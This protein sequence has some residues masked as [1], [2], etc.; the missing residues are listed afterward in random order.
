MFAGV[1]PQR[2]WDENFH[3]HMVNTQFRD[4]LIS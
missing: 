3:G 2:S 1:L 4:L